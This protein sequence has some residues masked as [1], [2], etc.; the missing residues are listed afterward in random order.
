VPDATDAQ[1]PSVAVYG[2]ALSSRLPG[3]AM[4]A[5]VSYVHPPAAHD[6]APLHR[7]SACSDVSSRVPPDTSAYALSNPAADANAQ[8]LPHCPWFRTGV[9]RPY[10]T[11]LNAPVV[12]AAAVLQIW[13]SAVSNARPR[14]ARAAGALVFAAS[15]RHDGRTCSPDAPRPHHSVY[16][17]VKFARPASSRARCAASRE[18]VATVAFASAASYQSAAVLLPPYCRKYAA[19]PAAGLPILPPTV[20]CAAT[21]SLLTATA[22]ITATAA[23]APT[24]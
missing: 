7:T 16:P 15:A 19:E 14:R 22:A 1:V 10:V 3:D 5:Y 4:Y 12:D 20:C 6:P 2:I 21:V 18:R 17:I 23:A 13:P 11:Q 24:L 9:T 8:Q